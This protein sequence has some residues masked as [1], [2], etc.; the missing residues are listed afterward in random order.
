M[1]YQYE[2]KPIELKLKTNWVISR[3]SSLTKK[4]FVLTLTDPRGRKSLS[5][6]APN[7]RYQETPDLIQSEFDKLDKNLSPEEILSGFNGSMALRFALESSFLNLGPW[8]EDLKLS[9]AKSV[10][11]SISVPIMKR[12]ELKD[13]LEKV[14][15]FKSIKVKVNQENAIE[16][17]ATINKLTSKA[18]RV[19]ANEA[20]DDYD[21]FMR[22]LYSLKEM[23][24]EFIE[25]P[26][27]ASMKDE[28]QDLLKKSPYPIIAD[29]SVHGA[30]VE[31]LENLRKYFHGINIKLMKSGGLATAHQQLCFAKKLGLKTMMGCM[32]ESGL[33]ISY[34]TYFHSLCDYLDLDGFLLISHDPYPLVKEEKGQLTLIS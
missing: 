31:S 27:K 3:N 12:E 2:L 17:L 21:T 19:D 1:N 34:A 23:R 29:E 5:E 18:L 26:F 20:F 4:N 28:Y 14:K 25:Q 9:K 6:V 33:G 16:A 11:T 30:E 8:W 13:Y 15:R 32:I 7:I 22:F 24:I 10:K